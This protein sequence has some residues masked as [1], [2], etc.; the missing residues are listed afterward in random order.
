MIKPFNELVKVDISKYL[1]KKPNFIWDKTKKEFVI[2]GYFNYL[3]WAKGLELL[4][5]FGAED[6]QFK[7]IKNELGHSVFYNKELG[8]L[9]CPEIRLWI[10]IDEKESEITYPLIRGSKVLDKID[11]LDIEVARQRAF[12]KG[13]AIMTGLGLSEWIKTDEEIDKNK[14]DQMQDTESELELQ[15]TNT[16]N[17][18]I[19]VAKMLGGADKLNKSIELSK[20]E[21][22]KLFKSNVIQDLKDLE[23]KITIAATNAK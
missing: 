3:N 4:Y 5:E 18:Y 8:G 13:I 17:K 16:Q 2:K 22:E 15:R 23:T 21:L 12:T 1:V 11:Q 19:E 10:K 7:P 9:G 14:D 20:V 6:V